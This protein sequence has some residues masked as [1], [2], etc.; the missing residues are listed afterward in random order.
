MRLAE[1]TPRRRRSEG[2][3]IV[4][5]HTG[6]YGSTRWKADPETAVQHC[7]YELTR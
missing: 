3:R 1:G 2:Y 7:G 5:D 6:W 4:I